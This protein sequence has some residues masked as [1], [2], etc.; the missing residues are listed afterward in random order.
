MTLVLDAEAQPIRVLWV[1][2]SLQSLDDA[3]GALREREGVLKK[4]ITE[5]IAFWTEAA[6]EKYPFASAIGAWA[7]RL[8]LNAV[9]WTA[10][11]IKHPNPSVNVRPSCTEVIEHLR[12]L[13][14]ERR[15]HAEEYVRRTPIQIDTDYRRSIELELGWTPLAAIR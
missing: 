9:V 5:H 1:L 4:N 6:P 12:S 2:M 14:H 13:T 7:Q 8:G 11:G 10:L 3:V 15:R